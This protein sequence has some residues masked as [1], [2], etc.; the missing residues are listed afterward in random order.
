MVVTEQSDGAPRGCA[1]P[2]VDYYVCHLARATQAGLT[3][4]A[5]NDILDAHGITL[6][7]AG[8]VID[9]QVADRL[10]DYQLLLNQR[11]STPI[12]H[13]VHFRRVIDGKQ[14]FHGTYALFG[15]Y[16]DI[17]AMHRRVSNDA[18]L[19]DW[20]ID[21]QL[22][23]AIWQTLTLL[24]QQLPERF[25][26]ALFCAWFSALIAARLKSSNAGIRRAYLAGLLRDIGFLNI[27]I[28]VLE[29]TGKLTPDEWRVIQ[30]HVNFGRYCLDR[31]AG[32]PRDVSDAVAQHHERYDG[33]GYPR[34]LHGSA[35]NR[36]GLVAGL[37]DTVQAMRFRQFAQVGRSVYDAI[38]Y[39]QMNAATHSMEVVNAAITL[40]RNSG[41][42]TTRLNPRAT[43]SAYA[44][45]LM[46]RAKKLLTQVGYL[47]QIVDTLRILP[48]S[49]HDKA[50]IEGA[51]QVRNMIASSGLTRGELIAWLESMQNTDDDAILVEL[52]E[53]DLMLNELRWHVRKLTRSIDAFFDANAGKINARTHR[54]VDAA[55]T[56]LHKTFEDN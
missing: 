5:R 20:T 13:Q 49:E 14:L 40:L 22:P 53:L 46:E 15:K 31:I 33:S 25:G 8:Q 30:G 56:G 34:G 17:L 9:A 3:V 19:S 21:A 18:E 24:E 28:E 41:L 2:G 44:F 26:E 10:M 52:N 38:P 45:S 47:E 27:P 1:D 23:E 29:K 43:V 37:A 42:E 16:P 6:V 35:I 36:L 54:A 39:L 11:F 32:M 48:L 4:S 12:S 55:T 7:R 50:L 51:L